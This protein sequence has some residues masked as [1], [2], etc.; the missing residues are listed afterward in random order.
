MQ[1]GGSMQ[2]QGISGEMKTRILPSEGETVAVIGQ[3]GIKRRTI[4][5]ARNKNEVVFMQ[6]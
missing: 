6:D 2:L 3:Q 4:R 5:L 1:A